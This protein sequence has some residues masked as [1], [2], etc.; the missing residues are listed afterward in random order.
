MRGGEPP[1]LE[2][3]HPLLHPSPSL[4]IILPPIHHGHSHCDIT[5]GT[6]ADLMVDW[7]SSMIL[8]Q[9]MLLLSF[10]MMTN[11]YFILFHLNCLS[12]VFSLPAHLY[13]YP[14]QSV[15]FYCPKTPTKRG[16]YP[17]MQSYGPHPQ[18]VMRCWE[19][20]IWQIQL[21]KLLPEHA[22]PSLECLYIQVSRYYNVKMV[23]Y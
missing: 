12:E 5:T 2:S 17:A 11:L 8:L 9:K 15:L 19:N 22:S 20:H 10:T 18:V 16:E 14:V 23:S 1:H 13:C 21:G 6:C 7:M 3:S 4:L